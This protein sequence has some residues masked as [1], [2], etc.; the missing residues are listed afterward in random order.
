[1]SAKRATGDGSSAP[2]ERRV[3]SVDPE[4]AEARHTQ[5]AFVWVPMDDGREVCVWAAMVSDSL[6]IMAATIRPGVFAE[7]GPDEPAGI[8]AQIA[9]ACHDGEPPRGRRVFADDKIGAID[10]LTPAEMQRI[11]FASAQLNGTDPDT[12][13]KVKAFMTRNGDTSRHPLS[14]GA[15]RS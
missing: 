12:M 1:M 5:R 13:E 4:W 14:T 9:C 7:L 3:F 8:R 2:R 10:L 6:S 11:L 15:S